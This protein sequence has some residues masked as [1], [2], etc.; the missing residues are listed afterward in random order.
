MLE[1]TVK[2]TGLA[3][4]GL[5]SSFIR[6]LIL[7]VVVVSISYAVMLLLIRTNVA[8]YVILFVICVMF[9]L[10]LLALLFSGPKVLGGMANEGVREIRK[11]IYRLWKG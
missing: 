2:L 10:S 1:L 11:S 7:G 6:H 4:L 5:L 9:F 3:P 8:W